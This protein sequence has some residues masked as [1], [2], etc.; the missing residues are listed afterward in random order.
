[1]YEWTPGNINSLALLECPPCRSQLCSQ[2][3]AWGTVSGACSW[4]LPESRVGK[5]WA[6]VKWGKASV[7]FTTR[8]LYIP[9][10]WVSPAGFPSKIDTIREPDKILLREV[11]QLNAQPLWPQE[12]REGIRGTIM[13]FCQFCFMH[14]MPNDQV[15]PHVDLPYLPREVNVTS[16]WSICLHTGWCFQIQFYFNVATLAYIFVTF[17]LY[18]SLSLYF[19]YI[20]VNSVEWNFGS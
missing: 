5:Q 14:F 10:E 11:W 2:K 3:K 6:P 12:G 16:L 13:R 9:V 18:F 8:I 15:H 19:R 17:Y 1:M 4:K 20:C 7:V